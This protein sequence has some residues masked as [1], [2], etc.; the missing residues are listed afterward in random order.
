MPGLPVIEADATARKFRRSHCPRLVGSARGRLVV[1]LLA[2]LLLLWGDVRIGEHLE[3]M[4][5]RHQP[6]RVV[7]RLERPPLGAAASSTVSS[8]SGSASSRASGI[9]W[10]LWIDRP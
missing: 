1:I 5:G 4:A 3:G 9:A 10:P 8:A 6:D 2:G 7:A